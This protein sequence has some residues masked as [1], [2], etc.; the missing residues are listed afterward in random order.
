MSEHLRREYYARLAGDIHTAIDEHD[1]YQEGLSATPG[2]RAFL[3]IF[4]DGREALANATFSN[5]PASW[6]SEIVLAERPERVEVANIDFFCRTIQGTLLSEWLRRKGKRF[7][8]PKHDPLHI[9]D[10]IVRQGVPKVVSQFE[11]TLPADPADAEVLR[12]L[13]M[14]YLP[15]VLMISAT[16]RQIG[17][18]GEILHEIDNELTNEEQEDSFLI[19]QAKTDLILQTACRQI[20]HNKKIHADPRRT[21]SVQFANIMNALRDAYA[22]IPAQLDR[23]TPSLLPLYVEDSAGSM[24]YPP[25]L[26][27]RINTGRQ[28]LSAYVGLAP[29][30]LVERRQIRSFSK[31]YEDALRQEDWL[32]LASHAYGQLRMMRTLRQL[33]DRVADGTIKM[34]D[35]LSLAQLQKNHTLSDRVRQRQEREV[36]LRE[37]GWEP[38]RAGPKARTGTGVPRIDADPQAYHPAQLDEERLAWLEELGTMWGDDWFIA[39]R[40]LDDAQKPIESEDDERYRGY[41][42]LVLPERLLTGEIIEHA[43]ADSKV[44]GKKAVYVYRAELGQSLGVAWH[45]VFDG[46]RRRARALGAIRVKHIGDYRFRILDRLTEP[47]ATFRQRVAASALGQLAMEPSIAVKPH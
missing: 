34:T 33:V 4:A 10:H 38:L 5:H 23:I 15:C 2:I 30:E 44:V 25:H 26:W 27:Q 41:Y 13:G 16:E 20:Q 21:L 37:I 32:S 42:V 7:D 3:G 36:H 8:D 6:T 17:A 29:P 47:M 45:H 1:A 14:A 31:S 43:I 28:E 46:N 12:G 19:I 22:N 9:F 11:R 40:T 18:T 24:G 39:L 35:V